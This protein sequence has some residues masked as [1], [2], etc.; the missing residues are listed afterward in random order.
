MKD[1]K[2]MY[3][4]C[5]KNGFMTGI[6]TYDN[7]KKILDDIHNIHSVMLYGIQ[8]GDIRIATMF[9]VTT[10]EICGI[11]VEDISVG[12]RAEFII[13]ETNQEEILDLFFQDEVRDRK[14]KELGI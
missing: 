8:E 12:R 2:I 14:L 10:H 11:L 13:N 3:Y 9:R 1:N 4:D 6:F 5:P 7:L